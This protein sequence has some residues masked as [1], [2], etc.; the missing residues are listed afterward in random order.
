MLSSFLIKE[1]RADV[2]S[3]DRK[4]LFYCTHP[5]IHTDMCLVNTAATI[6]Q[7]KYIVV[8]FQYSWV[9]SISVY[10]IEILAEG[11]GF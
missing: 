4:H 7:G 5:I 11:E 3:C 10:P 2:L 8:L 1:I 6:M 9:L